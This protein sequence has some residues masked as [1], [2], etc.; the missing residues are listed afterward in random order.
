M[1]DNHQEGMTQSHRR[2]LLPTTNG[3]MMVMGRE[4]TLLEVERLRVLLRR[5]RCA[6]DFL[7]LRVLPLKRLP[8][9]SWFPGNLDR[10]LTQ[11]ASHLVVYIGTYTHKE[12]DEL[13]ETRLFSALVSGSL[14]LPQLS[15]F[16]QGSL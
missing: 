6:A 10:S 4:I 15:M 12:E 7:P 2:S 5:G 3:D 11:S 9:L 1:I 16:C 13:V 14:S 8:A